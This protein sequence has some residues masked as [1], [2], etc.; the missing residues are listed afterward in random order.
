MVDIGNDWDGILADEFGK[1]YY[2]A[3][4]QFLIREYQTG[5]VYPGMKDIFNALKATP[6][7]AVEVVI[8]GQDPYHGPGQAHG[9][10]F[11]VRPGVRIPPSLV[12]I[13]KEIET[14]YGY[15]IPS[16]GCLQGWAAQRVLLLNTILTVRGGSPM[17]HKDKG[18]EI[19]TDEIIRKLSQRETPM[20]FMLWGSPA[21][22]KAGL[23]DGSRHLILKTTHP[24]PLSAFRGF[25]GC[26]HFKLAN[27]F[28]RSQGLKEI[29]W[30]I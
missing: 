23:I 11:S 5:V 24:S 17:S 8:L 28:L 6:Y 19:L 26:G 14:E 3:L 2:L 1:D 15:A 30:R 12:N 27:E 25:M 4:R 9:M 29:D 18:W 22:K 20:V 10:S 21:Q 7:Q 16:H 13:Y